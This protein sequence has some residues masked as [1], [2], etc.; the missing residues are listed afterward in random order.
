LSSFL[1]HL[2]SKAS[3]FF[4]SLLILIFPISTSKV[5]F[6]FLPFFYSFSSLFLPYIVFYPP[7]LPPSFFPI[8]HFTILSF[9]MLFTYSLTRF[10]LFIIFS[11]LSS[12]YSWSFPSF[13]EFPCL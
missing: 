5:I 11:T 4:L 1:H 8:L 12:T 2:M 3:F 9:F 13:I 6:F 7:I 10:S